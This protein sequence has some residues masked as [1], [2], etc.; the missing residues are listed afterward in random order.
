MLTREE[1]RG[2]GVGSISHEEALERS[3]L[4]HRRQDR[5]DKFPHLGRASACSDGV[6]VLLAADHPWSTQDLF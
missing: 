3:D 2:P 4:Y 1:V 6:R 5:V